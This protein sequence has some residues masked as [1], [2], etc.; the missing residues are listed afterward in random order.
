MR[1]HLPTRLA[2]SGALLF[3]LTIT[4]GAG[5]F[6]TPGPEAEA[7]VV[8]PTVQF[9][10]ATSS[11][12]EDTTE[13]TLAVKLSAPSL[14]QVSV[15]V[16]ATGGTATSPDDF[17]LDT[18]KVTFA[19]G[20]TT[21][22]VS[23][24]IVDDITD[25]AAETIVLTLSNPK[26]ATLGEQATHTYTINDNDPAPR[27]CRGQAATVLGLVGTAG[28]DVIV[29]TDDGETIRGLGGN[30]VICGRGGNDTIGAGDGDDTVVGGA[31]DDTIRGVSGADRLFGNAG[32]DIITG[33]AGDDT[34]FG[35][36][37]DDNVKGGI[38]G[39]TLRGNG[40]I[41]TLA[42]GVG[43]D[44]LRGDDGDDTL[45]GGA[46]GDSLFGGLGADNLF[47]QAGDDSFRG[48]P[49]TPD[50]CDGGLGADSLLSSASCETTTSIP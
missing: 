20:D 49:G 17:D 6:A 10:A 15:Q 13:V 34:L 48:G 42:G 36:I 3:V 44:V 19:A 12:G 25:E 45:R 40:G 37:G 32:N 33:A 11:G 31:G 8:P 28:D 5:L 39:D 4:L 9:A 43:I 47:G 27:F 7:G 1:S 50:V 35:N 14:Q 24:T 21:D 38:G 2:L 23:L 16:A 41:D 22:D 29:G 26:N 18:N 30:D 46:D